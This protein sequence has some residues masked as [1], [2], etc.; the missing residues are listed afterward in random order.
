[1]PSCIH[2]CQTNVWLNFAKF[3][4]VKRILQFCHIKS[5]NIHLTNSEWPIE[6]DINFYNVIKIITKMQIVDL[7]AIIFE[8]VRK[9]ESGGPNK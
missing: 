8:L 7:N 2:E 3:Y 1:M 4:F 6:Y 9:T 5:R